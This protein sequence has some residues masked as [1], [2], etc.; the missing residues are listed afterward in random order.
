DWLL[1]QPAFLA[2]N[3]PYD[4]ALLYGA[5]WQ[6]NAPIKEAIVANVQE[7][8]RRFTWPRIVPGRAE[9]FFRDVE[10]RYGTKIPVR[11][12]DTGL[13]WE[14]GAASTAAQLATF[15][16]AQLAARAAEIVALWDDRIEPRDDDAVQR[17]RDRAEAR[18]GVWRDV[19]L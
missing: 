17:R 11:R 19:L 2:Q 8:A 12:G 5:D 6:D 4:T 13:Y 15:R 14:D 18:V 16:A 7:F 3:W 1:N 9:D 10:R